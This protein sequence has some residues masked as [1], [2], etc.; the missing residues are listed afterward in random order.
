MIE[1]TMSDDSSHYEVSL[2]SGQAL[3]AFVLL[4]LSLGA[5]FAFGLMIGK[6][7]MDE[8]LV[9]RS[10]PTVIT[11]GQPVP[12]DGRIVELGAAVRPETRR[13]KA[14]ANP[15]L[16]IVEEP[17]ADDSE[18]PA[19]ESEEAEPSTTPLPPVAIRP[20]AP[21]PAR[22]IRA[23]ASEQ[24]G[25]P[26]YAQLLSTGD[27]KTA[28]SLAARLIDQGFTSAYVE[29]G[30]GPQGMLYRV[31]VRFGAEPEARAAVE[32]LKSISKGEIWITR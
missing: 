11:E 4:L 27:A 9:V 5:S 23:A 8:R 24:P 29:R 19:R 15:D 14:A 32:R 31:R 13:S 28:E 1:E 3:V 30:S 17:M 6:G 22:P 20:P 2:T 12:S 10:E 16:R 25:S 7:Q 18:M 26:V 21:V